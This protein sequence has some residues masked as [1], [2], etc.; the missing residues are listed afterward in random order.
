ML[1]LEKSSFLLFMISSLLV[2]KA[3]FCDIWLTIVIGNK[4]YPR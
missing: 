2:D 1:N 3:A 4:V